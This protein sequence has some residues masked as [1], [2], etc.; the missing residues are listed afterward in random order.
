MFIKDKCQMTLVIPT[1]Y[2]TFNSCSSRIIKMINDSVIRPNEVII[3]VSEY[4]RYYKYKKVRNGIDYIYYYKRGKHNQ[5]ENRN[6]GIKISKCRYISFFD[7][8]D[9]MSRY[10]IELILYTLEKYSNIDFILHS[11]TKNIKKIYNKKCK[12][13]SIN[14]ISYNYT[15]YDIYNSYV[16]NKKDGAK[17]MWCC[18]YLN[19]KLPIHNAWLSGKTHI[20]KNNMYNESWAYY[21]AEDTELNYRLILKKYNFL[22]IKYYL[23]LYI[24]R[25]KCK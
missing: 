19:I 4:F 9:Y 1:T 22:L 18:K 23:G 20:L 15:T 8:D 14:N 5:A 10:R 21:R 16:A 3:V 13:I 6:T 12:N 24:P 7:S 11:Y 2:S 25:S 17:N